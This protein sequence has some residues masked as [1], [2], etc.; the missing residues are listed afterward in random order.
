[1]ARNDWSRSQ[2]VQQTVAYIKKHKFDGLD[3]NWEYPG[4]TFQVNYYK[5]SFDKV[6]ITFD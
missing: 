3:L 5:A 1:M 2:F 6:L 4:K